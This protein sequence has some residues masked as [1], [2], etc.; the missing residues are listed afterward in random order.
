QVTASSASQATLTYSADGLPGG[1]SINSTTGLISGTIDTGPSSAVVSCTVTVTVSDGTY[2]SLATFAWIVYDNGNHTP[3]LFSPGTQA[4]VAGDVVNLPITAY[5]LDDEPLTFSATGLPDGLMIDPF[6]GTM[7]G[8][9]TPGAITS[10]T[11]HVVTVSAEDPGGNLTNQT[12][13]WVVNDTTLT[14]EG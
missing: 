1:L 6:T 12:F 2:S 4:N 11:P 8:T 13:T 7:T 3:V 10:S 14:A 9:L 5:D